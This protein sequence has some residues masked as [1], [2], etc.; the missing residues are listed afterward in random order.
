MVIQ[1]SIVSKEEIPTSLADL[2]DKVVHGTQYFLL[3]LF[4]VNAFLQA[5]SRWIY[6]HF[7]IVAWVYCLF[8]GVLTEILQSFTP[9]R[10]ADIWDWVA[11]GV[12]CTLAL[13]LFMMVYHQWQA[14][15]RL[16]S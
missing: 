15:Q 6:R 13:G 5:R 4:S 14:S 7:R 12:G 11:D 3:F 16:V 9:D 8:I 2:N 10:S 1:G